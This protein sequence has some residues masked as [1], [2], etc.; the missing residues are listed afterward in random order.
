VLVMRRRAGESFV[1][2]DTIEV[3][4]LEIAGSRVKLGIVAP[5][6]VDI[7]RKETQITRN[8]NLTAAQ[9]VQH[10]VIQALLTKLNSPE[11][12]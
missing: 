3:E 7:V 6:S 4:I 1:I 9:T 5:Q 10:E 8:E 2:G 11:K 12:S